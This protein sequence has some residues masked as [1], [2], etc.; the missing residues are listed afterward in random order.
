[1]TSQRSL[2]ER[3]EELHG[4]PI[5]VNK[6]AVLALIDN[7]AKE[8]EKQKRQCKKDCEEAGYYGI[9]EMDIY[10][11]VLRLLIGEAGSEGTLSSLRGSVTKGFGNNGT[12]GEKA[13]QGTGYS[14][15]ETKEPKQ[16]P[17]WNRCP[18]C[19]AYD[20]ALMGVE[21]CESCSK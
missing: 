14:S 2:R 5:K 9:T 20:E 12:T 7:L 4:E 3:V 21:L 8:I 16:N 10:D 6:Y 11:D 17:S 1:M 13:A 15:P 18:K 19:G